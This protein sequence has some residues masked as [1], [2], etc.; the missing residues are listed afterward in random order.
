MIELGKGQ[1]VSGTVRLVAA[2][3]STTS[4]LKPVPTILFNSVTHSFSLDWIGLD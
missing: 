1:L 3:S 4:R 2:I